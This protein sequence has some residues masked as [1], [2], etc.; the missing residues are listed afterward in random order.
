M[1]MLWPLLLVASTLGA[2]SE[3]RLGDVVCRVESDRSDIALSGELRLTLSVEGPAPVEVEP[4]R[5]LS[6]SPDWR[7]RAGQPKTTSLPAS[8]ERWEQ[9]FQLIP[10]QSGRVALPLE[11]LRFRTQ[12]ELRDRSV[13]WPPL[14]VQVMSEISD[15]ELSKARGVTGID[16]LPP[17]PSAK[18]HWP[19]VIVGVVAAMLVLVPVALLLRR[20]TRTPPRSPRDQAIDELLRLEAENSPDVAQRL[21]DLVRRYLEAR[22]ELAATRLTTA[23]FLNA[24][25]ER[26][27]LTAEQIDSVAELL[28]NG[29]LAKFADQAP[30]TNE[31]STLLAAARR[32]I[33]ETSPASEA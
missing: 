23:E 17:L 18:S 6:A 30:S 14:E 28:R 12:N 22:C 29:D 20:R 31:C 3:Q 5:P 10:F 13:S 32:L 33:A 8:R 16:E 25:R 26:D 19:I 9:S 11:P 7:V 4:P 21:A 2:T 15:A 27:V 1:S 24:L